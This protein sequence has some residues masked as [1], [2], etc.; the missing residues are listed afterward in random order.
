ME[1]V[2]HTTVLTWFVTTTSYHHLHACLC[3][4][5]IL[6]VL[7]CHFSSCDLCC[8]DCGKMWSALVSELHNPPVLATVDDCNQLCVELQSFAGTGCLICLALSG[9]QRLLMCRQRDVCMYIFIYVAVFYECPNKYSHF[10]HH[11][12]NLAVL[13]IPN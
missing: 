12:I 6:F 1:D 8:D 10:C 9:I 4:L 3:T 5:C 7:L 13:R 11:P 2:V